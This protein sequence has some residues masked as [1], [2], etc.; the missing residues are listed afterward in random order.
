MLISLCYLV[1]NGLIQTQIDGSMRFM[2][3]LDDQSMY[4]LYEKFIL[5]YYRKEFPQIMA[6]ASQISWQTDDGMRSMLPVMQT[7]I[8]LSYK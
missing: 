8:M 5:E 4:R 2:D 7:D 3:Y 1:V 6:E